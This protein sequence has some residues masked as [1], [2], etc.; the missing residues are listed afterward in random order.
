MLVNG[1]KLKKWRGLGNDFGCSSHLCLNKEYSKRSGVVH[2]K[3][4]K[5]FKV[6]GMCFICIKM[7]DTLEFLLE[8]VRYGSYLLMNI[9]CI[10]INN[11]K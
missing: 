10:D 8:D 9:F 3:N 5:A 11:V 6:Q 4:D 2:L 7:F 1:D